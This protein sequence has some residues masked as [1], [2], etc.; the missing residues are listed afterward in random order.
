MYLFKKNFSRNANYPICYS[1]NSIIKISNYMRRY[2]MVKVIAKATIKEDKV[3]GF[4]SSISELV[5]ETRK[6]DGCL[7]Y[8]LFQDVKDKK[9]LTFIEEW[10][11]M[12]ALERHMNSKHFQEALPKIA[13]IQEKEMELSVCTLV[14]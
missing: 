10:D 11:S 4:K 5:A 12:E 6:E 9:V 1:N 13:A 3:E 8:Q 2:S 14:I 7:S